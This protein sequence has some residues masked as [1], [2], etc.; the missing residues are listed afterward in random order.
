M[1]ILFSSTAKN[2]SQHHESFFCLPCRN[3]RGI[4]EELEVIYSCLSNIP[5]AI[6]ELK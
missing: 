1:H 5:Q 6:I 3:K 4:D 2:V